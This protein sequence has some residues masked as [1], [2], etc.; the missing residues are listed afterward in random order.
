[1][2]WDK[3]WAINKKNADPSAARYTALSCDKNA[4]LTVLNAS[5][6]L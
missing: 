6:E 2:E 4:T 3:L 5:E 1:M